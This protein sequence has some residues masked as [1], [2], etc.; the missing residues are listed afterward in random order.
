MA[1][2]PARLGSIFA[3]MYTLADNQGN[4]SIRNDRDFNPGLSPGVLNIM[5]DYDQMATGTT[6][7]DLTLLT[8][9]GTVVP[10]PSSLVLVGMAL[11]GLAAG[12]RRSRVP[13]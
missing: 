8:I 12:R 6:N 1:V 2:L 4:F 13:A 9:P 7:I 11:A 5:G 10:K 3:D